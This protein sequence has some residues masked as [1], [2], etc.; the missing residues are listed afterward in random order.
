M[1][2]TEQSAKKLAG[3]LE[4]DFSKKVSVGNEWRRGGCT[5]RNEFC[6]D[7]LWLLRFWQ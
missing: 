4:Y 7:L 2:A 3:R 5:R 6:Q 1:D